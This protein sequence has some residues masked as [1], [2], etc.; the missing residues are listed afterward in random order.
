ME[1]DE[2]EGKERW[3]VREK[4]DIMRGRMKD[5]VRLNT[6]KIKI[7]RMQE[8]DE[9]IRRAQKSGYLSFRICSRL[10]AFQSVNQLFH[11][12]QKQKQINFIGK[13]NNRKHLTHF[14]ANE[15][16]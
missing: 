8:R 5:T 11:S 10:Y 13:K 12:E 14:L 9:N 16:M 4:R 3:E 6:K 15:V 1:R 2:R 7:R